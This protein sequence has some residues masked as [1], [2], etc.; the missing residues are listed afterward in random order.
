MVEFIEAILALVG[1]LCVVAVCAGALAAWY[2]A[3]VKPELEAADPYREGLE[4]S[5]RISSAAW[6]AEKA[7]HAAAE[8]AKREE[9]A[10]E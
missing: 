4:A 3:T 1:F 2:E 10:G 6:E 9:N 8:Q 7:M 5:A